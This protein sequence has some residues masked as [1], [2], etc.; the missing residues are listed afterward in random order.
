V[1]ALQTLVPD[2]SPKS[3]GKQRYN[4]LQNN[5]YLGLVFR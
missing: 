1:T 3:H 4:R 2:S 5:K